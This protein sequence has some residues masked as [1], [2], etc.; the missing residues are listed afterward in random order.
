MVAPS[1][2]RLQVMVRQLIQ[3]LPGDFVIDKVEA[4]IEHRLGDSHVSNGEHHY[5]TSQTRVE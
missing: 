1:P 5:K 2:S 4:F 3:R